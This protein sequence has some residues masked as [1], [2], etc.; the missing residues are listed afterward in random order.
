MSERMVYPTND[1]CRSW[2]NK[3]KEEFIRQLL[4]K[5]PALQGRTLQFF[6]T[7]KSWNVKLSEYYG[8]FN[9]VL[10]KI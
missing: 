4:Y 2:L 7:N 8:Y 9:F 1:F 5:K 3:E 10:I 6:A